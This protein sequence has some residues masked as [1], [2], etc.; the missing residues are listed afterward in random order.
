MFKVLQYS[1]SFANPI[2]HTL[3]I[4]GYYQAFVELYS[5]W[6]GC[7]K[8]NYLENPEY[9]LAPN[10]DMTLSRFH[11]ID[12]PVFH[13]F[14]GFACQL[15]RSLDEIIELREQRENVKTLSKD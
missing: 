8:S 6:L 5:H 14:P 9:P 1:S 2:I 3:R 7:Q 4:P 15:S 11:H 12:N 13:C 10:E